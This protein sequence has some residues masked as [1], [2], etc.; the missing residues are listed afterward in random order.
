[1]LPWGNC[2]VGALL[3][4]CLL[5][6]RICYRKPP[7]DQWVGHFSIRAKIQNTYYRI[8]Y[9]RVDLTSEVW[10]LFRGVFRVRKEE[11]PDPRDV[12]WC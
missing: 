9:G 10:F 11:I 12:P 1:M 6:G 7:D 2:L 3:V 5:G 4:R 8:H